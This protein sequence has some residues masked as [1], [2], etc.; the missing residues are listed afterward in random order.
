MTQRV[1]SRLMSHLSTRGFSLVEVLLVVV[2]IA[3]LA[4]LIIPQIEGIREG[5]QVSIARQQQVELQTALGNW[6]AARSSE[7]GG[8]AGARA[9]YTGTKLALLQ[10]YLQAATY[11]SLAG[12]GD[13]V[14][15]AALTSAN[16]HLEFSAWASGGQPAV[17]WVNQ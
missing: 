7:P 4:A 10:N 2:I 5:A 14:T 3:V 1:E 17:N 9:A 6:I 16:A 12:S 8:L 11:S 13:T 15:S